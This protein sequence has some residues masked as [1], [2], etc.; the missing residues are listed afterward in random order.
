MIRTLLL[1]RHG[2]SEANRAGTLEGYADAPLTDLGRRQAAGAAARLAAMALPPVRLIASPLRR[3]VHTAQPISQALQA[4]VQVD[5]RLSAGESRLGQ[6]LADIAMEAAEAIAA[7]WTA[8]DGPLVAVSHRLPI[9]AYLSQIYG[10]AI[11][12]TLVDALGN[13]D[14]MEIVLRDGAASPA[15][16]H[17]LGD[18]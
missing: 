8:W 10:P 7:G 14:I 3:A 2:K 17:R 6:A 13:G 4:P 15:T 1:V 18:L 12:T 16:H 9:R 5:P 11:G